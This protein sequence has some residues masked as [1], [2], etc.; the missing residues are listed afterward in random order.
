V[1]DKDGRMAGVLS[2]EVIEHTLHRPPEEVPHGAD[3]AIL[4]E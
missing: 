4:E 2:I 3:A 1:V